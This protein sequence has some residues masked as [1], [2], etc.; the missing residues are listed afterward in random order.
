MNT[1]NITKIVT[2]IMI[3]MMLL[4]ISANVFAATTINTYTSADN[5]AFDTIWTKI[6]GVIR[7][8]GYAVSVGALV[9]LGIKYMMGSAEEK[10]EY[11]KSMVPY[12]VGA[13]LVFA[14]STVIGLVQNFMGSGG[15]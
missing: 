3:I 13:V 9:V 5:T 12:V 2:F 15:K 7:S 14:T 11:K 6:V 4:T 10:S 1:K 8:A